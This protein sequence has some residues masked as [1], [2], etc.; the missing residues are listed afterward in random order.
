MQRSSFSYKVAIFQC[1]TLL[2]SYN[3]VSSHSEFFY[4]GSTH[5]DSEFGRVF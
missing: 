4:D 3:P 5:M 2:V 1:T